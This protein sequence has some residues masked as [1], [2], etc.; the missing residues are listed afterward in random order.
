MLTVGQQARAGIERIFQLLDIKPAITDAPDAT[1][2]DRRCAARWSSM[3]STSATSDD[4]PVL[5]GF[6]MRVQ[7]GERVALVGTSGSGK[8]TVAALLSRFHDP[9]AGS[10]AAGRARPAHGDAALAAVERRCRVRGELPVLGHDPREHRL[11]PA[12]GNRRTRSR[13]RRAPRRRTTSSP[14][15]PKGYD[16]VVGERGLTLSGGQRQRVALARAILADPRVLV[17]DDATSAVDAR[18]EE[19]IHDGLRAVLAGRTTLLIAH[20]VSTLH[21]ADRVVVL[22]AGRVVEQGTHDELT[23]RSARYRG[24]LSGLEEEP[25]RAAGDRIEALAALTADGVTASA[26]QPPAATPT[27]GARGRHRRRSGRAWAAA[28]AAGS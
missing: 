21:L 27:A 1:D 19:A 8:S 28:V 5:D 17:L 10:R 9:S 3:T 6:T 20:R 15:C 12:V 22:D 11:R 13:P 24:L 4:A 23:A 26:W 18:T 25:L 2:A 14:S 16:T 7:A